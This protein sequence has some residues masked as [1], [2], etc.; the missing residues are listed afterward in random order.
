MRIGTKMGL[1]QDE[2]KRLKEAGYYHDIGKIT[3]DEQLILNDDTP[4][5]YENE[6]VKNHVIMGYRI[7]NAFDET[8]DLAEIT[9]MHHEKWDG[10][11]Y[12]KG[13]S[14]DEIPLFSRIIAVS[15]AYD[16]LTNKYNNL[17]LDQE[18]ALRT[19]KKESGFAYDPV[20]VKVLEE[21]LLDV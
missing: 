6:E 4:M 7:L 14:H 5:D 12:P 19:I 21:I 11:G 15:E 17:K 16:E 8:T 1:T 10:T 13:L 9:L 3:L 20:I 2:C 18:E